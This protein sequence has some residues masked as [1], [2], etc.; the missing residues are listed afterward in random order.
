MSSYLNNTPCNLLTQ[1]TYIQRSCVKTILFYILRTIGCNLYRMPYSRFDCTQINTYE[2]LKCKITTRLKY[3]C[4]YDIHR[5]IIF[6]D[7]IQPYLD[8]CRSLIFFTRTMLSCLTFTEHIHWV[9][10][11]AK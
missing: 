3:A 9:S 10:G 5:V 6:K 1:Y 2:I 7:R 4:Y 8:A 11:S